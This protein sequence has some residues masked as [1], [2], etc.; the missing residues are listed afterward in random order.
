MERELKFNGPRSF[1]FRVRSTVRMI[2]FFPTFGLYLTGAT[3][4]A[5]FLRGGKTFAR[6]F[7]VWYTLNRLFIGFLL[8]MLWRML[9][10]SIEWCISA[11]DCILR[12]PAENDLLDRH[13]TTLSYDEWLFTGQQLDNL[14]EQ[15][16]S[17]KKTRMSNDYDWELLL[18]QLDNIHIGN[19]IQYIYIYGRC[20]CFVKGVQ[21][22]KK[23]KEFRTLPL[24][25]VS[26]INKFVEIK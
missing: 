7:L 1:G 24:F 11:M 9:R 12:T 15:I 19:I 13:E 2:L 17:W 21:K 5:L 16:S 26:C 14:N 22:K 10:I 25:F 20:V 18:K 8:L 6:T 23:K 3:I 4:L